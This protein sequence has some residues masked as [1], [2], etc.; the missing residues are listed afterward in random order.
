MKLTIVISKG[1]EF[2]IG[3]IKEIPSVLSQGETIDKAKENVLDALNF[4]L[5]DMQN[6]DDSFNKVLEEDLI[7]A[8][9]D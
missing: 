4:Y 2:F 5:E 3:T 9:V 8:N 7:I 6:E 1:Q